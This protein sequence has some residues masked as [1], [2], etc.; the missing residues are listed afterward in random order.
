MKNCATCAWAEPR[1]M[2]QGELT[3]IRCGHPTV[4]A[5]LMQEEVPDWLIDLNAFNPYRHG[6]DCGAWRVC[7]G[8]SL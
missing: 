2:S 1:E 5:A 8:E 4:H 7:K 6:Q 3:E